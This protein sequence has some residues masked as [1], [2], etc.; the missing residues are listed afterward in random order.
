MNFKENRGAFAWVELLLSLAILVLVLQLFPRA[1]RTLLWTLD[2]RN[3][4][5]TVWIAANVVVLMLLVSMR[6][7]PQLIE[8]WRMRQQR[9]T[10]EHSKDKK[11]KDMKEQ[12]EA[13]ERMQ[14]AKRRRIY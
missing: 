4:P 11:Q 14:Q 1:G 7:G 5:R 2:V 10:D 13:L 8:D 6:F 9:L 12:R 3:W